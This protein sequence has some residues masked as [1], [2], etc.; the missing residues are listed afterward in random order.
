MT[1]RPWVTWA[2]TAAA[3]GLTVGWWRGM[4][5]PRVS[6]VDGPLETV[7]VSYLLA[8]LL[9]IDPLHLV[10]NLAW[11][12]RW[13]PPLE[14]RH[15]SVAVAALLVWMAFGAGAAEQLFGSVGVGLSGLVYGLLTFLWVSER[16][17]PP[18][19]RVVSWGDVQFFA[20]WFVFCVVVTQLGVW[21]I[22]NVAHGSGAALGWLAGEAWSRGPVARWTAALTIPAAAVA[23]AFVW[24][25]VG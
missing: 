23:V 20:G 24:P 7:L 16:D 19:E 1:A 12:W 11:V 6:D 9:H 3:L 10:F 8:C 2:V 17:R 15:G 22:G 21:R 4:P 14:A 5:L 13:A 18:H 25:G